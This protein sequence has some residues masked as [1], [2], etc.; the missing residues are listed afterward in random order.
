MTE[1]GN[2]S[3]DDDTRPDPEASASEVRDALSWSALSPPSEIDDGIGAALWAVTDVVLRLYPLCGW[4][5]VAADS[6]VRGVC[7]PGVFVVNGTWFFNPA[8]LEHFDTLRARWNH[9]GSLELHGDGQWL[10]SGRPLEELNVEA[11]DWWLGEA[12][13]RFA[14]QCDWEGLLSDVMPW[15]ERQELAIGTPGC[16]DCDGP[17]TPPAQ[18]CDS[19]W[20]LVE[21]DL[22]QATRGPRA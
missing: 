6:S 9:H 20:I 17:V 15:E 7:C 11:L 22:A 18:I 8:L 16:V 5:A 14:G 1:Y 4:I 13:V 19:C 2:E 21:L 10:G 3:S 12:M